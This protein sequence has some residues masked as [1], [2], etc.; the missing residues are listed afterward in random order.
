MNRSVAAH[1]DAMINLIIE[2]VVKIS[3][4]VHQNYKTKE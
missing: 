1:K 2:S 4:K 3:P